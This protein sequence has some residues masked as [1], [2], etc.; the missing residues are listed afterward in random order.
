MTVIDKVVIK[1]LKKELQ[2]K[3]YCRQVIKRQ[4]REMKAKLSGKTTKECFWHDISINPDD[5]PNNNRKVLLQDRYGNI[6][7]GNYYPKD[8]TH[9]YDCFYTEFLEPVIQ[10]A[11]PCHKEQ[12]KKWCEFPKEC[13]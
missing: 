12:I 2:K 5:T 9:P 8:D 3:T 11:H 13:L 10:G 1:F 6:Y 7:T 4:Y